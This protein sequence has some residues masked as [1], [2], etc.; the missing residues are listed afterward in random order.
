MKIYGLRVRKEDMHL[1][2]NLEEIY[3]ENNYLE[4]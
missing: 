4:Y 3:Y 2:T 1:D